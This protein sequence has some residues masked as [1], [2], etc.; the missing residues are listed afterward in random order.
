MILLVLQLQ[1]IA[2]VFLCFGMIIP[3]YMYTEAQVQVQHHDEPS[4][5]RTT[6]VIDGESRIVGGTD[7]TD[8]LKYPYLAVASGPLVHP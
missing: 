3:H 4:G 6:I 8:R 7:I 2:C 5:G 1:H